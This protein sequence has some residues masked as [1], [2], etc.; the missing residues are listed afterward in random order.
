MREFDFAS[1]A[2][3]FEVGEFLSCVRYG[4]GHINDTYKLT[5]REGG[6][7]KALYT[8]AHK[9]PPLYGRARADAATSSS[10]LLLPRE[11]GGARRGSPAGVPRLV[12]AK[13]GKSY[14]TDGENWFR[15]Y[16][17]IENAT[18]YQTVRESPR[19]LRERRRVRKFCE[20]AFGV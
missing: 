4:E 16:V 3:R 11:R 17:F 2:A 5:V 9:Q 12:P 1:V 20:P 13:D 19:F 14:Y 10:Y 7:G 8:S 15:V 6:A 18:T